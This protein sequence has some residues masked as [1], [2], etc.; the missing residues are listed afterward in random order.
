MR[1]VFRFYQLNPVSNPL[2]QVQH[3]PIM[4]CILQGPSCVVIAKWHPPEQ[5]MLPAAT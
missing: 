4:G 1:D 3:L 5:V 2:L